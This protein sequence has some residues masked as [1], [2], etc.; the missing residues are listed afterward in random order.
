MQIYNVLGM[1]KYSI[2]YF[3]LLGH[4]TYSS[5]HLI[6]HID[7]KLSFISVLNIFVC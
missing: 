2:V 7:S 6:Q 3:T 1:Q 5:M 4:M